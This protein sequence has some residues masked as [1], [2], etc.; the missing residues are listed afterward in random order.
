MLRSEYASNKVK[1]LIITEQSMIN[2]FFLPCFTTCTCA[3]QGDLAGSIISTS[4]SRCTSDLMNFVCSELYR[5]EGARMGLQSGK[6]NWNNR[7]GSKSAAVTAVRPASGDLA[8]GS[9]CKCLFFS[10]HHERNGRMLST[11]RLTNYDIST[12]VIQDSEIRWRI[13]G[14]KEI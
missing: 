4:N 11:K 2:L 12:K 7:G 10:V 3:L 9:H 5:R 14:V 8:G 1:Q 6:R 13:G